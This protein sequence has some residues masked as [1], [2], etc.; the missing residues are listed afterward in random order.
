MIQ[1]LTPYDILALG[2]VTRWHT[3]RTQRAQTLAD[4]SAR[5]ALL[6][7][8]LGHQLGSVRFTPDEELQTLRLALVHDVPETAFGDVP[9][10]TKALLNIEVAVSYDL[11]MDRLFWSE[12][13]AE[14]PWDH[15]SSIARRLVKVA[16]MLEAA[17]FYWSEGQTLGRPG[18]PA[19]HEAFINESWAVV[20]RE[21]PELEAAVS[22]VM[23]SAGV[24][25]TLAKRFEEGEASA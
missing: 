7:V 4:H 23:L 8:W 15:T 10:P 24:P 3:L 25:V 18:M 16:D 6:A 11:V 22:V 20:D 2:S 19:L 12:R 5:V 21:L 9:A 1:A 14:N 17:L 13:N